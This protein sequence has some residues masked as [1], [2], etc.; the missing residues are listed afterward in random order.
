MNKLLVIVLA[1]FVTSATA[2]ELKIVVPSNKDSYSINARLV[3]RH[4]TKYL[5]N[6]TSVSI[7]E[8][9]G[10]YSV[11]AANYL[12]E[13]AP[14]D[15]YTIGTFYKNIPLMGALGGSTIKYDARK[16]TWLGS[17]ADGRDDAVMLWSNK[18]SAEELIVG[19]ENI[20]AGD[21]TI[22]VRDLTGIKMKIVAGYANSAEARLA[23]ERKEIDAAVYS[24]IGIKTAKPDWLKAESEIKPI[25]QFGNGT[26]R[27][28]DYPN[29][30]TLSE[31]TNQKE[32]LTVYEKQFILLRPFVAPPNIP[33][34]R[35]EELRVAL[36]K[37]ITDEE[38]L[39]EA[40][41]ANID[42]KFIGWQEAEQ[43][44]NDTIG[45]PETILEKIRNLK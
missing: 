37:V 11:V 39:T 33:T 22:L 28:K 31:H 8:I 29:V 15:G 5:P 26:T 16:F 6:T 13:H 9:P 41:K 17:T 45:A 12:Y 25:L 43:I 38:F 42:V 24:L 20:V 35:A 10:A 1:V 21:A 36:A 7:Q 40:K 27:H 14:R 3:G 30:P 32:L 34:A 44:V 19:S 18:K 4:I 2:Q 23:L